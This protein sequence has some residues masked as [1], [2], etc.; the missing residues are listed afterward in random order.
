MLVNRSTRA[1]TATALMVLVSSG[2]TWVGRVSVGNSGGEGNL[3][4][5]QP[6]ISADGRFVAFTSLASNLVN[7]DTNATRD[8]FVRDA[9]AGTTIRVSVDSTGNQ[10]DG[11]SSRPSI[12][13]DGRYIAF[14][15]VASNLV[16]DDTNDATDVFVHDTVGGTTTRVSVDGLGAQSD[17]GGTAPAISADG[18]Y[19]AFASLANLVAADTNDATDVFVHDTSEGT[20]TR[21][22]VDSTGTQA[23]GGSLEPVMSADSQYVAF[24]SLA[25][26]LVTGDTNDDYDTFVRDRFNGVTTRVSVSGTGTQADKGSFEPAISADGRYVAFQSSA[27]S[28]VPDDTNGS[29]VDIFVRDTSA[30]T[31]TRV[32]VDNN[33]NE[34]NNASYYPSISADGRFV[35]FMSNATNLVNGDLN[36]VQDAFVRD[37]VRGFTNRVSAKAFGIEVTDGSTDVAISTDGRYIAFASFAANLVGGDNNHVGDVFVRANPEPA[38]RRFTPDAFARGTTTSVAVDGVDFFDG[39]VLLVDGAGIALENVTVVSATEI[40]ADVVVAS[41]APLGPRNVFIEVPAT[42][43]G[44]AYVAVGFCQGCV[45]V[46]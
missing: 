1:R 3:E 40:T 44:P 8:V 27:S 13:A 38:T 14:Q 26:N 39:A 33:K 20:T 16:A 23:N 11:E 42:G 29:A 32:S 21:V 19:V 41:D 25:S 5:N 15:S 28:L 4:S 6:A 36:G 34:S 9:V 43:P 7:G 46:D 18:R 24:T 22:S 30:D 31:T 2:C 35:A 12:S 45:T 17:L 37:T 10:G